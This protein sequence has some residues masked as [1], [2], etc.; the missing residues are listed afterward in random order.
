MKEIAL[1]IMDIAQ[2]S[3]RAGA[4][5]ISINLYLSKELDRLEITIADN[6]CGMSENEVDRITD[7]FYTSRNTRKVGMGIPMFRQHAEMTG[8]YMEISS[9]KDSGTTVRAE[10]DTSHPDA[11][12]LGDIEGC[13]ALL[14]AANP[15]LDVE[16]I[17]EGEGRNYSISSRNVQEFLGV[18]SL[19]DS[20][21]LDE[22]KGMIRNNIQELKFR[23]EI[24]D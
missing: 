20:E 22:L 13:W 18:D 2:N 15:N 24:I 8:G 3:I 17:V 11:Q 6:G 19:A 5:R 4:D 16:L 9:Q 10:F 1:H 7:P 14:A 21:L 12:P 23:H